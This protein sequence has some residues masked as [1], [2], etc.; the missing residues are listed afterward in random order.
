MF[1]QS[2]M[3]A[4]KIDVVPKRRW[5]ELKVLANGGVCFVTLIPELPYGGTTKMSSSRYEELKSWPDSPDF[6]EWVQKN[7][8][9]ET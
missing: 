5:P 7:N 1:L 9:E 2:D 3:E 8:P 4:P 6:K